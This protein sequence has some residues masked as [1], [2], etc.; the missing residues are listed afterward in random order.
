MKNNLVVE[1]PVSLMSLSN[2]KAIDLSRNKLQRVPADISQGN[3][4]VE[5]NFSENLL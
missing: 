4:L 3:A 5:L 1:I 2:L